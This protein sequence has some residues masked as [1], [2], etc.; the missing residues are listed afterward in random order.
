VW[1]D[2][3][4]FLRTYAHF[5]PGGLAAVANAMDLLQV[6]ATVGDGT[7]GSRPTVL[8]GAAGNAADKRATQE[9]SGPTGPLTRN[10]RGGER[11][12]REPGECGPLQDFLSLAAVLNRPTELVLWIS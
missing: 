6:D 7:L 9:E 2:V 1:H 12:V 10:F 5:Y 4:I 3:A 11:T 8:D